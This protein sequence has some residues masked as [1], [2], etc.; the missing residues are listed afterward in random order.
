MVA[1]TASRLVHPKAETRAEWKAVLSAAEMVGRMADLR[2]VSMAVRKVVDLAEMWVLLKAVLMVA[3]MDGK[4]VEQM[5]AMSVDKLVV[6]TDTQTDRCLD[7]K[8]GV[9][10]AASTDKQ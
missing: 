4:R 1:P 2:V 8:T 10:S 3:L 5:A 6:L 9:K 7:Q